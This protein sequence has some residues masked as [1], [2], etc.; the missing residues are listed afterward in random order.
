MLPAFL[1]YVLFEVSVGAA[2]WIAY[3]RE[4]LLPL[5]MA[6]ATCCKLGRFL[7]SL[8]NPNTYV[9]KQLRRVK[10]ALNGHLHDL[11]RA[12]QS[13]TADACAIA[14][15]FHMTTQRKVRWATSMVTTPAGHIRNWFLRRYN[16]LVK[17][18]CREPC[19][20]EPKSR[21]RWFSNMLREESVDPPPSNEEPLNPLY[22]EAINRLNKISAD[23]N[24]KEQQHRDYR[25]QR[26][27]LSCSLYRLIMLFM[28]LIY[29][30][31]GDE[32]V[33]ALHHIIVSLA[34]PKVNCRDSV[35]CNHLY[36]SDSYIIAVDNGSSYC[37][38]NDKN[39]FV[40]TPMEVN[41]KVLG[42]V[43]VA[44]SRLKGTVR[45]HIEDDLGVSHEL[46]IPNSYYHPHSPYKLL[47]PQ[48]WAQEAGD[49]RGMWNATYFDSEQLLLETDE[50]CQ[51][52][53]SGRIYQYCFDKII[54][55]L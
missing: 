53:L 54:S 29:T 3:D 32:P 35:D 46:L 43:G 52:Y 37:I 23:R 41:V 39:D 1:V 31:Q 42:V 17:S 9:P 25:A 48:H 40:G 4:V 14:L 10:Y 45:W 27:R 22:E 24:L 5:T 16:V 8:D 36:D 13:A 44:T 49:Q 20:A 51:D 34:A 38:T 19:L 55:A 18:P 50:A 2:Y 30:V 28:G 33:L 21:F 6:Y 12:T 7:W 26:H 15:C 47:S 11:K